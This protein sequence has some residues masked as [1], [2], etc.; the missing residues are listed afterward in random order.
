MHAAELTFPSFT[1]QVIPNAAIMFLTYECVV[2]LL[3]PLA[4]GQ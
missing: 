4:A 1:A 2:D 3:S